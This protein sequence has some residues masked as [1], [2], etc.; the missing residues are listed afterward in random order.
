MALVNMFT[1]TVPALG[2]TFL[3]LNTEIQRIV[4]TY[5]GLDLDE[6]KLFRVQG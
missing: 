2:R 1:K 6:R 3:D 4:L 5:F